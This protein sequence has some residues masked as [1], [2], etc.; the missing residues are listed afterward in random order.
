MVISFSHKFIF[1]HFF[2]TGGK[3]VTKALKP[4]IRLRDRIGLGLTRCWTPI[5]GRPRPRHYKWLGFPPHISPREL[6]LLLSS[7]DFSQFFKF[8]FVRNP[9]DLQVSLYHYM[10][11]RPL[12]PNHKE[13]KQLVNFDEYIKWR[14]EYGQKTQYDFLS[15]EAGNLLIDFVGRYESLDNDFEQICRALGCST[16]LPHLNRSNRRR[17][18]RSYYT[19]ETRALIE[20]MFR[21]DILKFGY[22]FNDPE[23]SRNDAARISPLTPSLGAQGQG[24]IRNFNDASLD[25]MQ[26]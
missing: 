22:S 1:F 13:I 4:Y 19:S 21:V 14:V 16:M 11:E 7:S 10:L 15:D 17:D 9:W 25:S 18:Y 2:K 8:A 24:G 23:K 20:E 3:S 6:K 12:H 5:F 26:R